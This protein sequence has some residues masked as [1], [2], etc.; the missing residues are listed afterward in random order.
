MA[1][2]MTSVS[3]ENWDVVDGKIT[4]MM[5][6]LVDID[7]RFSIVQDVQLR[8]L[9]QVTS[10]AGHTE[11]LNRMRSDITAIRSELEDIRNRGIKM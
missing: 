6:R 3:Q 8:M 5:M 10:I 9:E 4:N 2:A 11:N 7:D 1:K